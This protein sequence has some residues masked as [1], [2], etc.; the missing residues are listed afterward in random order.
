MEDCL[1][2]AKVELEQDIELAAKQGMVVA[3][4]DHARKMIAKQEEHMKIVRAF[5]A[6]QEY[7][8]GVA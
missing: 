7:A 2:Q 1:V 6:K 5:V 4:A 8:T 3:S